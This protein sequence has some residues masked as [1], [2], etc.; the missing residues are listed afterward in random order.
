MTPVIQIAVHG[1]V[2]AGATFPRSRP[3]ASAAARS[4]TQPR[5]GHAPLPAAT[6]EPMTRTSMGSGA[7]KLRKKSQTHDMIAPRG[8]TD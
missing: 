7:E 4:A 3:S 5:L 6:E 1:N 2:K 8:P